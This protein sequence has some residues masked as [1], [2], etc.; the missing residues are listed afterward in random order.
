MT[1][2][3]QITVIRTIERP[4][5]CTKIAHNAITERLA[6]DRWLYNHFLE[7]INKHYDDTKETLGLYDCFGILTE[8]R[9]TDNELARYNVSS[10]RFVLKRLCNAFV[11]FYKKEGGKP[12]FKG[13]NRKIRSLETDNF[14]IL[15]NN[16]IKIKGLPGI[17]VRNIPDGKIKLVRILKT[18]LRVTVQFVVEQVKEIVPSNAPVVGIDVGI[19]SLAVL[20]DGTE[21]GGR[22][23]DHSKI[24]DLQR[25]LHLQRRKGKT[26]KH[27][28]PKTKWSNAHRAVRYKLAKTHE[29]VRIRERNALHRISREIVN[30]H[31]NIAIEKLQIPN[32]VKNK[33]LSRRILE[34]GWGYLKSMLTYKSEETG[35]E[36][37]QV[38]ARNTSKTCSECGIEI[39]R[40]L[41]AAINIS[42]RAIAR[43]SGGDLVDGFGSVVTDR[44]SDLDGALSSVWGNAFRTEKDIMATKS[45]I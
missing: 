24:K 32:M 27:N 30:K 8:L 34:Q 21:Y 40:D 26:G 1:T 11:R 19:N 25:D 7:T 15:P 13:L 44:G 16:K 31:P 3:T 41:N 39:N 38:S 22:N 37:I 9:K 33:K 45:S 17:K 10:Q 6:K 43:P 12:R 14:R 29:R 23:R 20:S 42:R 18:A 4:A 35:G 2:P 5:L 36:V 28:K